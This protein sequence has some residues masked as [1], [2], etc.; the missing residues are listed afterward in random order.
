M[1]GF[2][3]RERLGSIHAVEDM[4]ATAKVLWER[5]CQHNGVRPDSF[6]VIFSDGNPF[7]PFY[8][9]ALEQFL[10]MRAACAVH[11]YTGLSMQNR[12]VYKR[13]RAKSLRKSTKIK[14]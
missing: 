12:D 14:A 1:S 4:G 3:E 9:K 2:V 13:K 7:V 8:R 5:C 10:E 11:G 6:M